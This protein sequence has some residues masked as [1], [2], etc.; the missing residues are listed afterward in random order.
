V[1]GYGQQQPVD[2]GQAGHP[3]PSQGGYPPN[4]AP[5]QP[6]AYQQGPSNQQQPQQYVGGPQQQAGGNAGGGGGVGGGELEGQQKEGRRRF[7]EFK[8]TPPPVR[9]SV[10]GRPM[11]V[12]AAGCVVKSC[13]MGCTGVL[14]MGVQ[15]VA[16]QGCGECWRRNRSAGNGVAAISKGS[17]SP[18]AYKVCK[19]YMTAST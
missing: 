9:L 7:R 12:W 11:F 5:Q 18:P 10:W 6:G 8:E 13:M 14:G 16:E 2:P 4:P 15:V 19:P 17:N 3:Y 1:Q